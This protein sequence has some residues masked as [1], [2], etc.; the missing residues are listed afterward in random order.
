MKYNIFQK[1]WFYFI[2][3]S[4]RKNSEVHVVIT[5]CGR[6]I[7]VVFDIQ[8]KIVGLTDEITDDRQIREQETDQHLDQGQ[9]DKMKEN[10]QIH[11]NKKER[12]EGIQS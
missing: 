1:I 9:T 4:G 6:I 7:N 12:Q 5:Y 2:T 8:H 10:R 11:N 3:I